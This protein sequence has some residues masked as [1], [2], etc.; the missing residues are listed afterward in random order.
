MTLLIPSNLFFFIVKGVDRIANAVTSWIEFHLLVPIMPEKS[1]TCATYLTSSS[2]SC[3]HLC[4]RYLGDQ[5]FPFVEWNFVEWKFCEASIYWW[6]PGHVQ[7]LRGVRRSDYHSEHLFSSRSHRTTGCLF[8][9][10]CRR[11]RQSDRSANYKWS[12]VQMEEPREISASH[13][14][15]PNKSLRCKVEEHCYATTDLEWSQEDTRD[16]V[17]G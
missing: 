7:S 13:S 5:L 11:A 3:Y 6:P 2:K 10:L 12:A 16:K 17:Q 14:E 15:D 4:E 9:F 8:F 1:S